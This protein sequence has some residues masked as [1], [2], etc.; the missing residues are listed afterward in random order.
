MWIK[1]ALIQLRLTPLSRVFGLISPLE[2]GPGYEN[3]AKVVL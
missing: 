1:I 3:E 2:T